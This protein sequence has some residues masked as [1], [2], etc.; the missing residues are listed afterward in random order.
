M[1]TP[2][3]Y[4]QAA[5][6]SIFDYF[7]TNDGNPVVAMPTGTGKSI[8]IGGF[9]HIAMNRFPGVKFLVLTHVKELIAQNAKALKAMWPNAPIGIHSAGLKQRDIHMPIIFGGIQSIKNHAAAIGHIDVLFIDECHLLSPNGDTMYQ[10]FIADLRVIN[11]KLK[12]VG[13]S[14]TPWRMRQGRITDGSLFTHVCC[15][16]TTLEWFDWFIRAGYLVPPIPKRTNVQ[17]DVSKVGLSNGE[18]ALGELQRAVDKDDVT[19]AVLRELCEFGYNRNKWLVF[20]S[21]I[22][23][24]EHLAAGLMQFGIP[25]ASIHSQIT[26]D[27]R[28]KRLRAFHNGELRCLTNNNVLTTGYDHPPIDLIGM[29]RPTLSVALWVQMVGRG[30]R[31]SVET[32]KQNCLV[33]DFAG[34]TPRLGPIN[35]PVIPKKGKPGGGDAPVKICDVC[36][37]YNHARVR[38]CEGCG[39]EFETKTTIFKTAGTD[40]LLRSDAPIFDDFKITRVFYDRHEKPGSPMM[41]RVRYVCGL[42]QFSEYITLEHPGYA[43]ARARD[44]WR[45]RYH[46]EPPKTTNDAL[47]FSSQL[48]VPT[49]I[50]VWVNKKYPEV[51]ACNFETYQ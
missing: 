46:E 23:H 25:A 47:R 2:R 3:D 17:F 1:I 12:V 8:V 30:M 20:A 51:V 14:A 24:S 49:S 15:D 36:G 37:C 5:I 13:F 22:E 26:S 41:M 16:Q 43:G 44:W 34:N 38:F 9:A 33:L 31:P 7:E 6:N 19:T 42:Q 4:Q 10:K 48:R 35:D 21:G 28:D 29:M 18:F 40:E 11:P 39:A 27:E 32:G 50:R 45:Q